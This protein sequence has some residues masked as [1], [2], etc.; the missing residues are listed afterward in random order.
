[1]TYYPTLA[2]DI[3]RAKELLER[4]RAEIA[5]YPPALL[6]VLSQHRGGGISGA[7][8][9]AAYK[10]LESFVGVIEAMDVEVCETAMRAARMVRGHA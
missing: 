10:L 5:D 7:D 8:I 3:A 9:Y 6:E 1:M 4:G 2:E